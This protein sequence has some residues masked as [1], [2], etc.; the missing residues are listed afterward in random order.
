MGP[1]GRDFYSHNYFECPAAKAAFLRTRQGV[2]TWRYRWFG[3]YPN[4]F[5]FSGSGAWHESEISF[6]F[7]TVE[8]MTHVANVPVED[9]VQQY[10]MGAWAGFVRNPK[11]ALR[12][13]GWPKYDPNSMSS[14]I[15][16]TFFVSLWTDH[17]LHVNSY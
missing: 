5:L 10:M 7:G 14:L 4:T 15:L 11:N 8:E 3:E 13:L 6:V 12:K 1:A 16:Q 9:K 17:F 2:P